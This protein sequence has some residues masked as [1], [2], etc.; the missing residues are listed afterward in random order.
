MVEIKTDF[1]MDIEE[2]NIVSLVKVYN[3]KNIWRPVGFVN[4]V[5]DL[6]RFSHRACTF[7]CKE[8]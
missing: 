2:V 7:Q 1:S 6:W 8:D 3:F 5:D 4:Q